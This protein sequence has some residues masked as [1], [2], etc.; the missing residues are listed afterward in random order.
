[1]TLFRSAWRVALG[2]VTVL[3]GAITAADA[4]TYSRHPSEKADENAVLAAGPIEKD[5]AFRFRAYLAKLPPKAKTTLHLDSTGGLVNP[6]LELGRVVH[7]LK[8]PTYV[9]GQA[10]C[11][12]A[13]AKIFLAGRD[14]E[15]GKPFRVKGTANNL[16][17]HNFAPA[18]EDGKAAGKLYV[19]ADAVRT[20]AGAQRTILNIATY[21]EE[22][23]ADLDLLGLSLK[24]SQI[25]NISNTEALKYGIHVLD[26][27][28]NELVR[29]DAA[30]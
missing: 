13:C 2:T 27:K 1:M 7:E 14:N 23:S 12:S 4:L 18:L 21:F 15:T 10:K 16:G 25:Y 24:Q 9:I 8:I 29:S 28:T 19:A 20:I 11:L 17:F 5:D 26:E 22:I 30:R 3:C 6:A